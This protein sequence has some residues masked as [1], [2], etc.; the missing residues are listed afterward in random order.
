MICYL[1][2]GANLGD[3]AGALSHALARLDA[4]AH[5]TLRQVSPVYETRAVADE[6][7]PDYLNLVAA[8]ETDLQP[9]QLLAA[10][11]GIENELGRA[12]P[13]RHAPRTMDMDLLLCGDIMVATTELTLPHPQM[14][15]R[16]FVLQPLADLDPTL[17]VGGAPPVGQ[18]T[19]RHDPEV[20][21]VGTLAELTGGGV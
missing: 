5:I 6:P 17:R 8:I 19:N 11:Q 4:H 2:L 18:L 13:Y 12:R 10:V 14:L 3:R 9:R 1:S 16:Q 21:L 7:Q 20:R 15:R